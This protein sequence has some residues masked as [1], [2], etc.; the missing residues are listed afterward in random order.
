[1][2]AEQA[3]DV[4]QNYARRTDRLLDIALSGTLRAVCR[5]TESFN[6][7]RFQ[8]ATTRSAFFSTGKENRDRGLRSPGDLAK[9]HNPKRSRPLAFIGRLTAESLLH[10]LNSDP[11]AAFLAGRDYQKAQFLTYTGRLFI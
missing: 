1:V 4:L 10:S 5:A 11:L 7:L 9:D 8:S 6:A 3:S 2:F